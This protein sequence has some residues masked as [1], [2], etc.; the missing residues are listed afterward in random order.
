[1]EQVITFRG[2]RSLDRREQSEILRRVLVALDD[3]SDSVNLALVVSLDGGF[4][5]EELPAEPA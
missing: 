5:I 1:M 2:I 4:A 3:V